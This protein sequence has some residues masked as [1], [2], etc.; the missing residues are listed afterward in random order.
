V[1][2]RENRKKSL[3]AISDLINKVDCGFLITGR[4]HYFNSTDEM[5]Q[6]FGLTPQRTKVL[7][8][9]QEFTESQIFEYLKRLKGMTTVPKWLPKR[10]LICQ[11]LADLEPQVLQELVTKETGEVRFWSAAKRAICE[12][13]ASIQ[14][15]LDAEVIQDV[16]VGLAR[17]SSTKSLDFGPLSTREINDVFNDVT[18]APPNDESAVILQRLPLLGRVEA[19]S[20]DRQF[21]DS[22]F[23][24]GLRAED[25]CREVFRQDETILSEAWR[26]PL[27]PFG[28][29]LL[30]HEISVS[31]DL[32]SFIRFLRRACKGPNNVLGGD[33]VC[34]I[35]GPK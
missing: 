8:C 31:A 26:N 23:L 28:I 30:V 5:Y 12:R 34:G 7:R 15:I 20:S 27:Q 22:Y 2:L 35:L 3:S 14:S 1:V 29:R 9:S 4:E 6:C 10:P 17:L 19:E 32:S 16:L 11:I 25:V 33:L 24:D 21:V 18:G 13:E